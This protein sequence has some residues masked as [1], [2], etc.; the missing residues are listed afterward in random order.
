[1]RALVKS[2]AIK[3]WPY[4]S[5]LF[6]IIGVAGNFDRRVYLAKLKEEDI[7]Q[8]RVE[9][10]RDM[11]A[12]VGS[13]CRFYSLDFFSEPYLIEIGDNVIISGE[14]IFVTHD[15]GVYLFKDEV[16]DIYGHFGRIKIGN[17]CFI[18]MG[19][20]ILP[21]IEIGDNC[22]IGA[23]AVVVDSFPENS[24]IMGNP[25]KLVFKTSLYKKMRLTSKLTIRHEHYCFPRTDFMPAEEKRK[26]LM[27]VIAT[28]P[29]KKP[30][31]GN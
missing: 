30:K 11:G 22:I 20:I 16:P 9:M 13:N 23:G 10:A 5:P 6:S 15:G 18:G 26:L 14:V 24:V 7:V 29:I 2:L 8:W 19:A 21:N 28:Q 12:K 4:V 1:M 17:N 3:L 31:K 27:D 25:A